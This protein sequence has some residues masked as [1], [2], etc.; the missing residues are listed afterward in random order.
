VLMTTMIKAF[1]CLCVFCVFHSFC[2]ENALGKKD[3]LSAGEL[4]AVA[5]GSVAT[6]YLGYRVFQ[7]DVDDRSRI[8]GP[9]PKELSLQKILG[10]EYRP[11]KTN[12]LDSEFGS[13]LTPLIMGTIVVTANLTWPIE[14]S[15]KD[16]GQDLT[17]F[18]SGLIANKGVTDLTKGLIRRPRPFSWMADSS[19]VRSEKSYKYLRTSFFSGHSSSAFY[20]ASF[21]NLRLRSIMKQRLSPSEYRSWRWAPPVALFSWATMVAWSR[22]HAYKHYP[23]DV[24]VG[25]LVGYLVSELFYSWA[26]GYSSENGYNSQNDKMITFSFRF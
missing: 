3:Y 17:L 15:K 18:I 8:R 6:G 26:K 5:G 20:S 22:I 24:A 23:S 19:H 21:A 4:A 25:A 11:G 13:A 12:F 14:D 7:I 16:A 10:G 1:Y 9:L 2:N